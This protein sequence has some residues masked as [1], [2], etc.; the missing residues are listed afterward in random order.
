MRTTLNL[1]ETLIDEA[2]RLS[3]HRTKTA[4]IIT[5]L[6]DFVR[7][8]KIQGLKRYK[9]KVDVDLDLAAVRERK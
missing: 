3:H 6:E 4:V 9:G 8:S 1:P 7:K 2:L 5:A